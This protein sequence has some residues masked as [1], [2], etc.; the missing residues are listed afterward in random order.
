MALQEPSARPPIHAV[1]LLKIRNVLLCQRGAPRSVVHRVVELMRPGCARFV[2][3]DPDHR[4]KLVFRHHVQHQSAGTLLVPEGRPKS[5]RPI[6]GWI[7]ILRVFV[8][9]GWRDNPCADM[10]WP[11]GKRGEHGTHKVFHVRIRLKARR[12]WTSGAFSD[13]IVQGEYWFGSL[14]RCE[15][16]ERYD[17]A[18]EI[19][20]AP[21]PVVVVVV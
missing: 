3:H 19:A 21:A 15:R 17:I 7:A 13:N 5:M 11:A 6:D 20:G 18:D 4:G 1:L 10:S 14:P 9:V 2:E 12:I 8:V 16:G